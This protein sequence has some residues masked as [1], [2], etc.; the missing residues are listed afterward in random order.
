MM[1]IPAL[2]A[3]DKFFKYIAKHPKIKGLHEEIISIV[4]EQVGS[5]IVL[6]YGPTGVGK[7]TLLKLVAETLNQEM[8]ADTGSSGHIAVARTEVISPSQGN[9]IDWADFY[10]RL[11]ADLKDPVL[12]PQGSLFPQTSFATI[13]ERRGETQLRRTLEN[14]IKFRRPKAIL[15]DE[16]QHWC[17]VRSSWVLR[18]QLDILKSLANCAEVP[19][20][21]FGTYDLLAMRNLNGQLGRRCRE[22]HFPRYNPNDQEDMKTFC[23]L[24]NTFV[25]AMP[26]EN[27]PD[28]LSE[29]ELIFLRTFGCTGTLKSWLDNA[30]SF[31]LNQGHKEL[32]KELF[33]NRAPSLETA[34]AIARETIYSENAIKETP[35]MNRELREMLLTSKLPA[36]DI[37]APQRML[38]IKKRRVGECKP[39]RRACGGMS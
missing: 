24:I 26:F 39:Q 18:K 27:K 8:S 3:K 38:P 30:V 6:V 33:I 7:T 36:A 25:Q 32:T 31:A 5:P 20:I 19:I 28:L 16:A 13:T 37:P 14:A 23:S 35:E 12:R 1:D 11:L 17:S 9:G 15:I 2:E 4:K 10:H 29:V 34:H 22:V 21:L